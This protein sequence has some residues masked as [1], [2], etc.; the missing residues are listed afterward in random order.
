MGLA[1]SA[2]SPSCSASAW[3]S[4]QKRSVALLERLVRGRGRV[5]VRVSVVVRVRVRVRVRVS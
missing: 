1:T 2:P 4:S 5:R 3:T